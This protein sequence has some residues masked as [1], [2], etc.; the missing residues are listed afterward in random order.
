M[1]PTLYVA[2]TNSGKLRDF[3]AAARVFGVALEP[4]PG[5]RDLDAPVEDSHT[6]EGN[7]RIKARYYSRHLPDALVLADD[8]GLEVDALGGAPG[9]RSAR[10]AADA[11]ND[12]TPAPH[13]STQSPHAGGSPGWGTPGRGTPGSGAPLATDARNNRHLLAQ[14]AGA[15]D[16]SRTARYRCV[17]ALARQG[18]VL[19]T[20]EGTVE[21]I[22]LTEARGT[23]GFGYDPLFYLPEL[24]LTMAEVDL[25]TK[26]RLSHRGRALH[27]LLQSDAL[28]GGAFG[29]IRGQQ[30]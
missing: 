17:L 21:G 26:Q 11:G 3:S 6:F 7:A 5:L 15:P 14:L 8:S 20:A 18:E 16:A 13:S 23:G 19:T 22:I 2:T 30:V 12:P 27:T 25:E 1:H 28:R 10:Y 4:L 9:V 24:R 29:C